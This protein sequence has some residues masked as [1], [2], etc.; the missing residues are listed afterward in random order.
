MTN[1]QAF[2]LEVMWKEISKTLKPLGKLPDKASLDHSQIRML[3]SELRDSGNIFRDLAQV[4]VLKK[5]LSCTLLE[6]L[7]N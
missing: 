2:Q 5:Y 6:N 7:V 3:Y 4:D 1:S